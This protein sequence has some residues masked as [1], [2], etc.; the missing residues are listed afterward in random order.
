[1]FML[2]SWLV[3]VIVAAVAYLIGSPPS[4]RWFSF[5]LY[6]TLVSLVVLPLL[7]VGAI[8]QEE[9]GWFASV[10]QGLFTILAASGTG[11]MAVTMRNR[12]GRGATGE[13]LA[14]LLVGTLYCA[15]LLLALLAA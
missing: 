15:P 6:F 2:L 1:M 10:M 12:F 9:S 8:G 14:S 7:A 4:A 11:G 3:V 13:S 5:S